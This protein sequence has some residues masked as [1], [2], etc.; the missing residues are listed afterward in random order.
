MTLIC[1]MDDVFHYYFFIFMY[2]KVNC[3]HCKL[4]CRT[5]CLNY[6]NFEMHLKCL[7]IYTILYMCSLLMQCP[8]WQGTCLCVICTPHP[9]HRGQFRSSSLVICIVCYVCDIYEKTRYSYYYLMHP[10]VAKYI[11]CLTAEGIA[12]GWGMC[13]DCVQL[14]IL[15][16]S[17]RRKYNK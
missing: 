7:Y 2:Y 3:T 12:L 4:L 8:I 1:N 15:I 13:V 5:S 17:V 6:S 9:S 16:S 10:I 11:T 14:F